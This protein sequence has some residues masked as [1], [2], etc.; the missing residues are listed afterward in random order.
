MCN[1]ENHPQWPS[2]FPTSLGSLNPADSFSPVASQQR[3]CTGYHLLKPS[4][5]EGWDYM[6]WGLMD[7]KPQTYLPHK[8]L[9]MKST[10]KLMSQKWLIPWLDF[11]FTEIN[12]PEFVFQ[13]ENGG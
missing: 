12:F 1:R 9:K 3:Q 13:K 2:E 5:V 7:D 6:L 10:L 8:L 11:T 4:R